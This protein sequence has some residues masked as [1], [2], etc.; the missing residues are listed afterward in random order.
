MQISCEQIEIAWKEWTS[1]QLPA[2]AAEVV[3]YFSDES[4]AHDFL[5]AMRWPNGVHCAHCGSE[6]IGKLSVS[7]R[8]GKERRVWNCKACKKQFTVRVGTMYQDSPFALAKWMIATWLVVNSKQGISSVELARVMGIR[9]NP[10]WQLRHRIQEAIQRG[11]GII[12]LGGIYAD[13]QPD[14]EV[15]PSSI[16]QRFLEWLHCFVTIFKK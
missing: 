5:V 15:E 16:T 13:K 11:G 12:L 8:P 1:P 2:T 7:G 14:V 10:A 9:Q 3:V 6:N 4:R